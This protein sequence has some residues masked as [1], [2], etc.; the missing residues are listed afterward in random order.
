MPPETHSPFLTPLLSIV[1]LPTLAAADTH[2][3]ATGQLVVWDDVGDNTGPGWKPMRNAK[4]QL[5]DSDFDADDVI[6]EG[7]TD[8]NG[9]FALDGW[10]GDS[11]SNAIKKPDLYVKFSLVHNGLAD[12]TDEGGTTHTCHT[13]TLEEFSGNHDFGLVV[14]N[15]T[16]P[17]LLYERAMWERSWFKTQTEFV[18]RRRDQR[19]R[20]ELGVHGQLHVLRNHSHQRGRFH[21]S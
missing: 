13:A 3:S 11:G 12:I 2:V 18:P 17:S 19:A 10:G 21:L 14:C 4:V 8:A 9:F 15:D 16:T 6:A 7:Q 20:P 5:M 1:L